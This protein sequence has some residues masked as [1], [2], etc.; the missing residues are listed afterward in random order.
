MD[1]LAFSQ[2][3]YLET[4]VP[5]CAQEQAIAGGIKSEMVNAPLNR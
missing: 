5:E 1:S 4:V 3:D 2:I